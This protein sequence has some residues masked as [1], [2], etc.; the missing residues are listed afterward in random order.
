MRYHKDDTQALPNSQPRINVA[1]PSA[2]GNIASDIYELTVPTTFRAN[3]WWS[4]DCNKESAVGTFPVS[5]STLGTDISCKLT[6]SRIATMRAFP[7]FLFSFHAFPFFMTWNLMPP[8]P[9]V[10]RFCGIKT[11]RA[12]GHPSSFPVL[13]QGQHPVKNRLVH[14]VQLQDWMHHA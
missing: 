4:C 9:C 7:C 12:L 13:C 3:I 5:Q 1:R 11:T 2:L 8:I 14:R 10:C 6:V